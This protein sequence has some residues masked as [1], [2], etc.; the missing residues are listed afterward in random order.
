[1]KLKAV[2]KPQT[3]KRCGDNR[4]RLRAGEK[5]EDTVNVYVLAVSWSE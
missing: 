1:M 5:L 3:T 2:V 4:D